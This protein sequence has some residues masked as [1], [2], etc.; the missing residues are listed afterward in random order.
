MN[1]KTLLGA[2]GATAVAGALVYFLARDKDEITVKYNA[3]EHTKEKLLE[4]LHT[5]ELDYAHLYLTWFEMIW[6]KAKEHGKSKINEE[7]V[8]YFKENINEIT[9]SIDEDIFKE[10]KISKKFFEEWIEKYKTDPE[11]KRIQDSLARNYEK[12]FK[13][14]QFDIEFDYP[15]EITK[16]VYKQWLMHSYEKLRYD[17][18]FIVKK[19]MNQTGS[20]QLTDEE[21]SACIAECQLNEI[22]EIV[23]K[24]MKLPVIEK[25][26]SV[27][28]MRKAFFMLAKNDLTWKSHITQFQNEHKVFL[29]EIARAVKQPSLDGDPLNKIGRVPVEEIK[30]SE[31]KVVELGESTSTQG[32]MPKKATASFSFLGDE[33]RQKDLILDFMNRNKKK[34]EDKKTEEVKEDIPEEDKVED[35]GDDV[36]A[37]VEDNIPHNDDSNGDEK[38]HLENGGNDE[39]ENDKQEEEA[40]GENNKEGEG[41]EDK[42]E[43]E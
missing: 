12:V 42:P 36:A 41:E 6:T 34:V 13:L 33:N 21:I 18:Y 9:E 24:K 28:T 35:N 5:F 17:L 40:N 3:K 7:A 1:S 16:Q 4:I 27:N 19:Q 20:K 26:N 43:K 14:E 38:D 22:K 29:L 2:I 39:Q 30:R 8:D 31:P 11:I 23:Y 25:E 37:D 15:R 32:D 10:H